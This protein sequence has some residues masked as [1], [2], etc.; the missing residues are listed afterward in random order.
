MLTHEYTYVY[1]AVDVCTGELDSLILPHVNTECIQ[2]LNEV[3][4]RHPDERIVMV[5]DGIYLLKL[6]PYAP[7]LNPIEHV[8]DELRE[9]FFHNR[10]FK[11]LDALEDHLTLA[12]KTLENDPNTVGSIVSGRGSLAHF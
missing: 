1:G 2:F 3:S 9:K 8:W 5:I 10:V 6:P 12:L 7:E 11:S 4:S